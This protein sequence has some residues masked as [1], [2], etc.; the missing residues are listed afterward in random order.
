MKILPNAAGSSIYKDTMSRSTFAP[1][2]RQAGIR[3]LHDPE[4]TNRSFAVVQWSVLN[5]LKEL[6]DST[7]R[8]LSDKGEVD[9]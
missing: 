5:D 7:A 1:S 2:V 6:I 3:R 9:K 4:K 8:S